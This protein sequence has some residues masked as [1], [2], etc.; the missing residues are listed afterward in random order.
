MRFPGPDEAEAAS[1][2]K[3]AEEAAGDLRQAEVSLET[4]SAALAGL[5]KTKAPD[6]AIMAKKMT[7]QNRFR[8][9]WVWATRKYTAG[10]AFLLVISFPQYKNVLPV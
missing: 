5:A 4:A 1:A 9:R 8:R 2:A 6:T 3:S 7:A 10:M